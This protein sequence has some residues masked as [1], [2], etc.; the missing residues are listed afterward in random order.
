MPVSRETES[1]PA[2]L[3]EYFWP[4]GDLGI[5]RY[6]DFLTNEGVS[7]GLIGPREP[8]R[9]WTRHLLN[10]VA[11]SPLISRDSTVADIG[12]G[13]GLPG[14]VL[15]SAR[16]DLRV[17]LV[18]PMQRRIRFLEEAVELMQLPNTEVIHA[19]A[20]HLHGGRLFDVVTARALAPLPRLATWCLPLV[21]PAGQLL[22]LKGSR[23][24]QELSESQP[25][26]AALGV[27]DAMIVGLGEGVLPEPA[28]VVRIVSAA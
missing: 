22:A 11:L 20:E 3:V 15:A 14:L 27:V 16:P 23:A 26:L 12:S 6:V 17:A 8:S 2:H 21:R 9:L 28:A 10:C 1:V 19:R 25:V 7:R 24:A 13:A 18:E 5:R 4:S